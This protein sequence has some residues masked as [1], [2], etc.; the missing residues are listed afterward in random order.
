M[1]DDSTADVMERAV[2]AQEQIAVGYAEA[3]RRQQADRRE[4]IATAALQG[5]LAYPDV[6]GPVGPDAMPFP[7]KVYK[8]YAQAAIEYA[9]ALIAELDKEDGP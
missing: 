5:L 6:V 4:R 1:S 2:R 9:D 7:K 3:L 8:G